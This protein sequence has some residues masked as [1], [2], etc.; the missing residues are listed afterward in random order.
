MTTT[1]DGL[2]NMFTGREKIEKIGLVHSVNYNRILNVFNKD[3][4]YS[5]ASLGDIWP[6]HTSTKPNISMYIPS[7]C[8]YIEV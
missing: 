1:A 4:S 6:E 5:K 2:I 7:I 3:C 8:R